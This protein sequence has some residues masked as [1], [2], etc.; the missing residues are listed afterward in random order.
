MKHD[1]SISITYVTV[2]AGRKQKDALLSA[3]LEAGARVVTVLYGKGSVQASYLTNLLGL[4]PEENKVV[5]VCLVAQ[6]RADA[7]LKMLEEKFSFDQPNTGIAFT[8]PIDKLS[9]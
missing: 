7:L 1:D 6:Q 2:I 3:L 4:V 5:I 8:I 9:F